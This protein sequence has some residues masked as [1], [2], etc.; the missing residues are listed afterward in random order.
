GTV[1]SGGG[2]EPPLTKFW[3]TGVES[4]AAGVSVEAGAVGAVAGA[5][6]TAAA[7]GAV[8]CGAVSAAGLLVAGAF[9]D[10]TLGEAPPVSCGR[11]GASRA[12]LDPCWTLRSPAPRSWCG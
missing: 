1:A 5:G 7:P 9:G 3:S 6:G 11:N 10:A 12:G 8:A 4:A 2:V